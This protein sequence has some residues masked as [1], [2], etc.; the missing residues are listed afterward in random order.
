MCAM[1]RRV[2]PVLVLPILLAGTLAACGEET[3]DDPSPSGQPV[4]FSG[5]QETSDG[6]ASLV[7][8]EGW[9]KAPEALDGPV[10][11]AAVDALEVSRQVFVTSA[12]SIDDAEAVAIYSATALSKQGARCRRDRT[13]GT[14]AASYRIVDCAWSES[15]P[16]YRKIMVAIG[17][18]ERG[19]MVLVA[20]EA[21]DREA[22][23][24][25]ITPLL[26]SWRWE[27]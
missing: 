5:R 16:P 8:P 20:G 23:A 10:T 11:L 22:L 27:G 4:P 15:T 17:D 24:E 9:V 1:L 19:A 13:D 18:D 12:A 14:F 7:L 3:K 25:L 2:V 6:A 26:A 21:K